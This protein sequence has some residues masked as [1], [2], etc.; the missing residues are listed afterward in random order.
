LTCASNGVGSV[1]VSGSGCVNCLSQVFLNNVSNSGIEISDD[2]SAL[3]F[4][5]SLSF[6]GITEDF[7]S[8]ADRLES[9]FVAGGF[10]RMKFNCESV[11]RALDF[12]M[13]RRLS[14]TENRVIVSVHFKKL[15]QP[16]LYNIIRHFVKYPF[17]PYK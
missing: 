14:N 5:V 4:V 6:F 16:A 13:T 1:M 10:V 8:L 3:F 9:L 7:V 12:P 15:V 17:C 2:R 11:V